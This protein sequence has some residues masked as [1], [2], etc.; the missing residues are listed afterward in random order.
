MAHV[1]E[2][3]TARMR[4]HARKRAYVDGRFVVRAHTRSK[5]NLQ[6]LERE[7]EVAYDE[8]PAERDEQQQP[9]SREDL[10]GVLAD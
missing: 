8:P 2:N 4:T 6:N 1:G 7:E 5:D 9:T 10:A 3:S